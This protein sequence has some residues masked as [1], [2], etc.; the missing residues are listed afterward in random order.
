MI[1]KKL[2]YQLREKKTAFTLVELLIVLSIFSLVMAAL[3]QAFVSFL[4]LKYNAEARQKI[5]SEGNYLMDRIDFLVRNGNT[6]PDACFDSKL[7]TPQ[8]SLSVNLENTVNNKGIYQK[9][10]ILLDTAAKQIILKR[11]YSDKTAEPD[12]QL[13]SGQSKNLSLEIYDLSFLCREDSFTKGLIVE[14]KFTVRLKRK[15][16]KAERASDTIEETFSRKT[17]VRNRFDWQDIYP[18]L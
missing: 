15:S 6:I 11:G 10:K 13:T 14:S 8:G 1:K 5:Q 2:S 18:S 12:L 4:N 7:N 9:N 16:L 17:A 3:L